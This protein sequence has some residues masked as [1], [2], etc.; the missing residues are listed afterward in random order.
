MGAYFLDSSALVKC[1]AAET[2]TA[3]MT[4]LINPAA[5]NVIYVARITGVGR[6]ASRQ[7]IQ[8]HIKLH[9]AVRVSNLE[10]LMNRRS[11]RLQLRFIQGQYHS[12]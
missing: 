11:A 2:G 6:K 8:I 1:Y 12:V 4:S 10:W 5:G 3:W 7:M 9:S